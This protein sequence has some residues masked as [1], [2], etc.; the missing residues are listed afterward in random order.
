MTP[1]AQWNDRSSVGP[2]PGV[3]KYAGFRG[4]VTNPANGH[5]YYLVG[6][7][8]WNQIESWAV[9]LFGGHLVTIN[10]AEEQA[11]LESVFG[12]DTFYWTGMND[13]NTEGIWEWVSGE[14]VTYTNWYSGEPSNSW[15]EGEDYG[16][17]NFGGPGKWNDIGATSPEWPFTTVGIVEVA[18]VPFNI[19]PRKLNVKKN[20]VLPVVISSS[21]N[22]D[23][24]TIDPESLMLEGVAPLRWNMGSKKLTLKFSAQEIVAAIG[25]VSDGEE[26]VLQLTGNLKEEFGG[27]AIIGE[28]AVLILKKGKTKPP[29][30]PKK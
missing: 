20:G 9:D 30:P 1:S 19:I 5:I 8:D 26:V 3:A 2:L 4:G 23:V 15:P 11:W 16:T 17:M 7:G 13:V 21:E 28:D 10:D 6:G 12:T 29:K 22:F 27:G 18:P 25:E 24:T 14:A